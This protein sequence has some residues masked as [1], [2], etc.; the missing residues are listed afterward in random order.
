MNFKKLDLSKELNQEILELTEQVNHAVLEINPA[1]NNGDYWGVCNYEPANIISYIDFEYHR[2]DQHFPIQVTW[3]ELCNKV[4][5]LSA[6][7]ERFD[8]HQYV[9]KVLSGNF[10]IHRHAFGVNSHWNFC[11][12]NNNTKTTTVKFHSPI[13]KT[14]PECSEHYLY[15]QLTNDD[16]ATV[17]EIVNINKGEI[18]SFNVWQWHSFTVPDNEKTNSYI[19]YIKEATKEKDISSYLE[20]IQKCQSIL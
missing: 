9:G 6:F 18:Y 2:N 1:A 15:D 3:E 19:F 5:K 16:P 11:V 7:V 8:L 20:K 4:P 13:N 12:L 17:D 10:G 14:Y